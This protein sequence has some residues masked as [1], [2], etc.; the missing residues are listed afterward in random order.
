LV[1]GGEFVC[2]KDAGLHH[3]CGEAWADVVCGEV[4]LGK[5]ENQLFAEGSI[6]EQ[7]VSLGDGF[8]NSGWHEDICSA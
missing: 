1:E 6:F 8:R 7:D 5:Q 2:Q 4:Q 3:G